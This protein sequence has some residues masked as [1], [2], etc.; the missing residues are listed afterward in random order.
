[1]CRWFAYISNTEPTLLEDVLIEPAH[2]LAKQVHDHYLPGLAHYEPD[3]DKKSTEAEIDMR[4]RMFN[5]DGLGMAWYS[6]TRC[7]F[8]ECDGIR[9][10]IYKVL[11]QPTTDPVFTSLCANTASTTLFAHIRAAS[12]GSPIH[13]YNAH[14]FTFGRH[15]FMHNGGVT[16][17]DSIRREV[18]AEMSEDAAKAMR[19]TSDSEHVA[20]LFFTYLAER[21]GPDVWD[22][23]HPL[24]E[25]KAALER[26]VQKI[27]DIQKEVLPKKGVEYGAS[28]LNI[29]I[30]DGEQLLTIRFRNSAT[31]HPPSLYL[32]TTAGVTL[33]RKYPGHPDKEVNNVANRK[34][35]EEHG[36]HVIV[37]SEP[38]TYQKHQWELIQKNECIMVGTDMVVKKAPV[39]VTF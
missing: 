6:N 37:A 13:I 36:D 30:T 29:A 33:N 32:S 17:F 26:A 21:R 39:N 23:R 12:P 28:S 22:Q 24:E 38:T 15:T 34:K 8:G 18:L 9:P 10:T 3:S 27:I 31:E 4:N 35:A 19:G 5:A 1:M 20:A 2:A 14:P 7:E 16:G 11:S 25:V